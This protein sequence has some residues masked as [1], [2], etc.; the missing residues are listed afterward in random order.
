M[1]ELFSQL[2]IDFRLLLSQGANFFIVLAAL[3]FF[4]YKPLVKILNERKERI[5]FGLRGAREAEER[6]AGIEALKK[7][8]IVEAEKNATEIIR[9]AETDAGL[10]GGKIVFDAEV[11]AEDILKKASLIEEQRRLESMSKLYLE[12][13]ALMRD[14]L[15]KAVALR[16]EV[17]DEALIND[18]VDALKKEK[19]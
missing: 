19:I 17:I 13:N 6:L 14:A 3:T 7:Q 5:E 8:K 12:A 16:P 18:A 10:R 15:S 11:K 1:S 2:G 4:V 9:A